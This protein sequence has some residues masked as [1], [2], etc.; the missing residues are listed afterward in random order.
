M[1][2]AMDSRGYFSKSAKREGRASE[3]NLPEFH[4]FSNIIPFGI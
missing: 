4:L 1:G 3:I 2:I